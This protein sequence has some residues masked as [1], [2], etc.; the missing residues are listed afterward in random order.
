MI[1]PRVNNLLGVQKSRVGKALEAIDKE[2]PNHRRIDD[3]G[4]PY[5]PWSRLGLKNQWDKYMD[6]KFSAAVARTQ[7]TMDRHLRQAEARWIRRNVPTQN[8]TQQRQLRELQDLIRAIAKRWRKDRNAWHRPAS[9]G[10]K[11]GV[12]SDKTQGN[13]NLAQ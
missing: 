7:Y 11:G 6:I 2:L 8:A 5:A 4:Q 1:T 10:V 12:R 9:W 3:N 13:H